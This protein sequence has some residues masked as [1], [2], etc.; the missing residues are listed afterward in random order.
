MKKVFLIS[1]IVVAIAIGLVYVQFATSPVTKYVV[2]NGIAVTD[3][4]GSFVEMGFLE[5]QSTAIV[6][7]CFS[8]LVVL[9]V[10]FVKTDAEKKK[11]QEGQQQTKE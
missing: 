3:E 7:I 5:V 11:S 9:L 4:M 8:W 6:L 1:L 10:A 2:R